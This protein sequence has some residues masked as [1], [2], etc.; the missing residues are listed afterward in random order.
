MTSGAAA[1]SVAV[2]EQLAELPESLPALKKGCS[3]SPHFHIHGGVRGP[4][5]GD[6]ARLHREGRISYWRTT[7]AAPFLSTYFW[8]LPVAVLGSS[9]TN[10]TL[11]GALK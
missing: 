4:W 2:G 7:A 3:P 5:P 1:N 6:G 8:I 9:C 11:C 10:V